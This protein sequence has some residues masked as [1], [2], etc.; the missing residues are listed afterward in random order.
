MKKYADIFKQNL[1]VED[2]IRRTIAKNIT[3]E[4]KKMVIDISEKTPE[5]IADEMQKEK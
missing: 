2:D 4:V 3:K 1:K 5:I